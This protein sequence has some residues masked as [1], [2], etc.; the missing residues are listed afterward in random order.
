MGNMF[1]YAR[2]RIRKK[3][4]S[5]CDYSS[6]EIKSIHKMQELSDIDRYEEKAKTN[7]VAQITCRIK[8]FWYVQ[9]D[10]EK[11]FIGSGIAVTLFNLFVF[12]YNLAELP[13][14][15]AILNA[16]NSFF[17]CVKVLALVFLCELFQ[18]HVIKNKLFY[19]VWIFFLLLSIPHIPVL[20][21]YETTQIGDFYEAKEYTEKYYV[22]MSRQPKEK[23]NRKAYKLPAEIERVFDYS[24]TTDVDEDYYS[25]EHGGQDVYVLNYHI[26]HLYFSNGGY[27]SF[28]EPSYS[29]L[30]VEKESEVMDYHGD[31]YYITL[32]KE[33]SSEK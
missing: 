7:F 29:M 19:G 12:F 17:F 11:F 5:R 27:L 28:D 23:E 9:T 24:Y 18:K 10:N 16:S 2:N 4:E 1:S 6:E 33:K 20:F 26:N 15:Y 8:T 30:Q 3:Y 31:T 14:N 21:G 32:T 13:L 22:I 25:Q